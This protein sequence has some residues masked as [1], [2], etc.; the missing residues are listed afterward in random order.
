MTYHDGSD[1]KAYVRVNANVASMEAGTY[2]L[3]GPGNGARLIKDSD[4]FFDIQLPPYC[5]AGGD[6]STIPGDVIE[7]DGFN[8]A[9]T[10][11]SSGFIYNL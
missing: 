2:A 7:C 8:P 3:T 6:N 1:A 10:V 11:P 4:G 5:N 9:I